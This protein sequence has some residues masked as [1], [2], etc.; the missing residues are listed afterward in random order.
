MRRCLNEDPK[1]GGMLGNS[2]S[3]LNLRLDEQTLILYL[4]KD[5]S[6]FF[7]S[8]FFFFFNQYIEF[9]CLNKFYSDLTYNNEKKNLLTSGVPTKMYMC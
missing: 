4:F 9:I 1:R 3:K 2:V 5:W 7:S 8:F 6:K